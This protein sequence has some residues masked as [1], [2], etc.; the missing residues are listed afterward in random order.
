VASKGFFEGENDVKQRKAEKK[1]IG[2]SGEKVERGILE[3]E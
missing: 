3:R 2:G 1:G